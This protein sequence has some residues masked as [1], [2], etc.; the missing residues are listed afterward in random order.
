MVLWWE[1]AIIK[2]EL[3]LSL[4]LSG[5]STSHHVMTARR[6]SPNARPLILDLAAPGLCASLL[7]LII[8][9]LVSAVL[10]QQMTQADTW[11]RESTKGL[12]HWQGLK[13]GLGISFEGAVVMEMSSMS[14][15][16]TPGNMVKMDPPS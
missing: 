1:E 3:G 4:S 2:G 11:P 12:D 8:K 9:C 15:G 16:S 10:Q 7:L 5:T 6:L 13:R 14:L